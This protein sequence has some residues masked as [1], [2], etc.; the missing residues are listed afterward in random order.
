MGENSEDKDA[1]VSDAQGR[2]AEATGATQPREGSS[3]GNMAVL[4]VYRGGAGRK[5]RESF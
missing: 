1:K 2:A 4:G 3:Q 5:G